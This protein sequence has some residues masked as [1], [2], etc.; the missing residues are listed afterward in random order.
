MSATFLPMPVYTAVALTYFVLVFV[1]ST[2]VRYLSRKLPTGVS[3]FQTHQHAI[4]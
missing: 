1:V 4:A 3:Y 2:A